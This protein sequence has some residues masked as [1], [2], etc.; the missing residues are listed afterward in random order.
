MN[1]GEFEILFDFKMFKNGLNKAWMAEPKGSHGKGKS[2]P[3]IDIGC[4]TDM[5]VS[6]QD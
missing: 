3:V 1:P 5:G 6:L 4:P 2:L